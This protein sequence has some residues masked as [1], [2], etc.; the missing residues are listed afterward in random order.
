[1]RVHVL[2][3]PQLEGLSVAPY[4]TKVALFCGMMKSLGHTV[5]AY[6][7]EGFA[8]P[9]LEVVACLKASEQSRYFP[10]VDDQQYSASFDPSA[11]GWVLMNH[12]VINE[13]KFRLQPHD[14][15]CVV[16]GRCQEA[17]AK[18][19]PEHLTVEFGVGYPGIFASYRVFESYAW[20]H[21]CYGKQGIENGAY[22][23]A[24]IPNYFDPDAF[25]LSETREPYYLFL[26]RLIERKGV[27]AA[28]DACNAAG[29][30]LVLAGQGTLDPSL[31][32]DR[33]TCLG[34]VGADERKLLLSKAQA[35]FMPTQYIEPF[36]SVQAE[37]MLSGAGVI[38]TDWGSF[39]ET[40]VNGVNGYRTRTLGDMVW[41]MEAVTHLDRQ[42][43]RQWAID[44]YS[45]DVVRHQYEAYFQRLEA[46]WTDG[47]YTKRLSSIAHREVTDMP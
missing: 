27:K 29:A 17:I 35:V 37:A 22:F 25:T 14:F 2:A 6:A 33:I 9:C 10:V 32:N 7:P 45:I 8:A 15:I 46:L 23:D 3:H 20:M 38:A 18:A 24:V 31:L 4:V 30:Q 40:I 26:G 13:L 44:R 42:A 19:F 47:W 1:M 41:A 21:Y 5:Y 39:S 43:I 12:R 28:I 34:A 11:T 16:A 36:G